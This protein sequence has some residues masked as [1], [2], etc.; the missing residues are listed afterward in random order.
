MMKSFPTKQNFY[1]LL[2]I[3]QRNPFQE[4]F[5]W[6]KF[7]ISRGFENI[8]LSYFE[9]GIF[10]STKHHKKVLEKFMRIKYASSIDP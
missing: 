5:V 9:Q 6:M 7:L 3:F 10:L 1:E 2:M 8:T 4:A